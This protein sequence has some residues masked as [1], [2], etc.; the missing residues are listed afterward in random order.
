MAV[1]Y[2]ELASGKYYEELVVGTVY[3]HN[4]A[5]RDRDGQPAFSAL[6]YNQV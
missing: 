5:H 6:T 1:N 4:Y 2:Q 3:K